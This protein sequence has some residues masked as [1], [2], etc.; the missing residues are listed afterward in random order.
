MDIASVDNTF[1][2]VS[3]V[4]KADGRFLF[5]VVHPCFQA[6]VAHWVYKEDA[7][8]T[9]QSRLHFAVDR[10][11]DRGSIEEHVTITGL[12]PEPL[13]LTRIRFHR[14]L[15]DYVRSL[16]AAGFYIND[17]RESVASK[18]MIRKFPDLDRTRRIPYFML[19]EA[20]KLQGK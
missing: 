14:T 4:M 19:I 7:P 2:E 5:N 17:L 10:Y 3:R 8:H 18:E 16:L 20:R 1:E 9:D 13:Y 11:F 6:R 12:S 15:E